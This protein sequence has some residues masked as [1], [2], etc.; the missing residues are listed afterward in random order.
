MGGAIDL[1]ITEGAR[2]HPER[3]AL[4]GAEASGIRWRDLRRRVDRCARQLA[5]ARVGVLGIHCDNGIDW[6]VS[7]LA[8]HV[9]GI[10]T[11]PLPKFFTAEQS[12]HAID[13]AAIDAIVSDE[14]E[15]LEGAGFDRSTPLAGGEARLALGDRRPDAP[16]FQKVTFTS[17]TTGAPKGV[18]LTRAHLETVAASLAESTGSL[19]SDVHLCCL[20][21]SI[22]LENV[23][24]VYRSLLSGG[25]IVAP[26]LRE[27]GLG[28]ARD[29]DPTRALSALREAD[30]TS[31]ILVPEMLKGL[32]AFSG[33]AAD[34]R[35]RYLGV[36]GARVA[37]ALLEAAH[38]CDLPAY[39]GYGLSEFASVVAL[40]VPGDAKLGAAGRPLPHVDL[41]ISERGEIEI[42]GTHFGGYLTDRGRVAPSLTSD[43]FLATGDRGEIDEDGFVRVTG[44]LRNVLITSYGRNVSP[45]WIESELLAHPLV[46]EAVVGGDGEPALRAVLSVRAPGDWI[47]EHVAAV[48]RRLPDYARIAEC[49]VTNLPFASREGLVTAGG[50]PLRDE[51]ERHFRSLPLGGAGIEEPDA[52]AFTSAS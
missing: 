48:N 20:P 38:S 43:G 27:V 14:I 24:G 4:V 11:V 23:A 37:P 25:T 8:A 29:F 2:R 13:T 6:I 40:N 46:A 10:P 19:S 22:L 41:R 52:W 5:D 34:T 31:A 44:R 35:L 21:L 47:E 12:R 30:A 49:A 15:T 7:D 9:S 32:V 3:V 17:G 33:G 45:E 18:C 26:S 50:A 36:G 1:A 16:V 39:E 51:V 28:G 42:G